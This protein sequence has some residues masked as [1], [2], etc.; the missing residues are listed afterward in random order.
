MMCIDLKDIKNL[1]FMVYNFGFV[2]VLFPLEL[3]TL[4]LPLAEYTKRIL[5]LTIAIQKYVGCLAFP[6]EV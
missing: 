6:S 1:T 4:A 5:S 3:P 2:A